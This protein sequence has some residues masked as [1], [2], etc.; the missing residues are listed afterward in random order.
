MRIISTRLHAPLGY[1]VGTLLIAARW[2]FGHSDVDGA[3]WTS[4]VA[5]VR[6]LGSAVMTNYELGSSASSPCIFTSCSMAA[7]G[8]CCR[9]P[10]GLLVPRRG[11]ERLAASRPDRP[12]EIAI[13]AMSSPG[14]TSPRPPPRGAPRP[15]HCV[16][17]TKNP[18][19]GQQIASKPV[20]AE[21]VTIACF[22]LFGSRRQDAVTT[23]QR[24]TLNP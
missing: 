2:I 22:L 17:V 3:K 16:A 19:S 23:S 4:I 13:A 20:R 15:P 14:L 8:S 12:G 18:T 7:S 5:G 11:H 6:V 24:P 1:V 9:D 21:L 10:L